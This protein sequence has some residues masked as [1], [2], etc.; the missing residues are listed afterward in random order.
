[1]IK[2]AVNKYYKTLEE[3][4]VSAKFYGIKSKRSSDRY[5]LYNLGIVSIV[6]QMVS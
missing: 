6:Y 1:M 4:L 5:Y 2:G 3:A